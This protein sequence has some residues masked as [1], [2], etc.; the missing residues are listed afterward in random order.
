MADGGAGNWCLIESD[1]GVF[2]ELIREFGVKGAQ[3]EEVWSMDDEMFS[4]LRPV[5]GLVFLFKWVPDSTVEGTPVQDSRLDNIFFAKQVINNACATQAILSVLMN[6][7]HPDV[8]LS[9]TLIELRD[10]TAGFD[11][12]TRGLALSNSDVIRTVHNSFARQTLFELDNRAATKDDDV[13][14][15]VSYIPL[16]GRLYELDGL[17]EAPLDHGPIPEGADWT[18]AARPIIEK[19]MQK[20]SEG[21][22]RFNLMAI[23]SDRRAMYQKQLEQLQTKAQEGGMETDSIQSEMARVQMLISDEEK[24]MERYR[25]ENIRRKHNYIPFIMELLKILAKEGKL[26]QL[27]EQAK[28][29]SEKLHQARKK[30]KTK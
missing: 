26:V 3:V 29:R 20:Y 11:P 5:H 10:F 19:R 2:T 22:I 15:F 12:A 18:Q 28:E 9:S 16:S 27:Y 7:N 23:I 17:K 24:K 14:H 1:P 8:E 6:T 25:T 4:K 21:E 30:Q 13:Y